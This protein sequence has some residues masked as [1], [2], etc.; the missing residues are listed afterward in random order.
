[1]ALIVS[2]QMSLKDQLEL[3]CTP[4]LMMFCWHHAMVASKW[5][6]MGSNVF[7]SNIYV[8]SL[9]TMMSFPRFP[10]GRSISRWRCILAETTG[11]PQINCLRKWVAPWLSFSTTRK[12]RTYN[13]IIMFPLTSPSLVSYF[14]SGN[15]SLIS[16][17]G[18]K[19]LISVFEVNHL[20]RTWCHKCSN[21]ATN[22]IQRAIQKH[23]SG[24][25][26]AEDSAC[27]ETTIWRST[28]QMRPGT[29]GC[30]YVQCGLTHDLQSFSCKAVLGGMKTFGTLHTPPS[31]RVFIPWRSKHMC[32]TTKASG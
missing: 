29:P 4:Q 5:C 13:Y 18:N 3:S 6:C 15:K 9:S 2:A 10:V 30:V 11:I 25:L 12:N 22:R 26:H 20:Q 28:A 23:S 27:C 17:C 7:P 32:N 19:I 1:M 24:T 31:Q 21:I 14:G 8:I 16:A